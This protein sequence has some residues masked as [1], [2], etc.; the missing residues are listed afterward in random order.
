MTEAV[1]D[2][3]AAYQA[4]IDAFSNGDVEAFVSAFGYPNA[5]LVADYGLTVHHDEPQMREFYHSVV[6]GL[7]KRDWARTTVEHLDVNMMAESVAMVVADFTRRRDDDSVLERGRAYY[8]L[9][10]Q[11]GAWKI[12]S[13]TA[14]PPADT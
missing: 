13:V 12:W 5:F 10:L 4:Y 7:R 2:I 11:A 3:Q 14:V 1:R 6:A 8:T 9:G